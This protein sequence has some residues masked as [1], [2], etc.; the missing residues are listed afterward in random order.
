MHFD[1][2]RIAVA[3]IIQETMPGLGQRDV[4]DLPFED[5]I[6]EDHIMVFLSFEDLYN[7]IEVGN[8]R[9]KECAHNVIKKRPSK[10][11]LSIVFSINMLCNNS[12]VHFKNKHQN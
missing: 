11:H 10:N 7:L 1:V 2:I 8:S 6:I 9:L 12:S 4:L 3:F 5:Q